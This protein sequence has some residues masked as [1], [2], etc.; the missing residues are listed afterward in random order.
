MSILNYR[1]LYIS[2][3]RNA[4]NEICK[5]FTDAELTNEIHEIVLL[6]VHGG[7][8]YSVSVI[9]KAIKR[10]IDKWLDSTTDRIEIE[11][12]VWESA[13]FPIYTGNI[14]KENL[15]KAERELYHL[16][17]HFHR[18]DKDDV[19]RLLKGIGPTDEIEDFKDAVFEVEERLVIEY[20]GVYYEDMSDEE[21]SK[22]TEK[23]EEE[24]AEYCKIISLIEEIAG[25][26][27]KLRDLFLELSNIIALREFKGKQTII[28][29]NFNIKLSDLGKF[30]ESLEEIRKFALLV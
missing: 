30:K 21:Y 22:V 14:T 12:D 25:A 19:D 10:E 26:N 15:E 27:D 9:E 28:D 4:Y 11:L 13:L 23:A 16:M 18:W 1:D 6:D 7:C 20:G 2:H 5:V 17:C 8:P 3:E 29:D 24:D